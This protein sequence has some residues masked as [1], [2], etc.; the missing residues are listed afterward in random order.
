MAERSGECHGVVLGVL[1]VAVERR[2]EEEADG[3]IMLCQIHT[4]PND[5]WLAAWPCLVPVICESKAAQR[6]STV[7][8]R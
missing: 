8:T 3:G 2:E 4:Q 1:V 5:G 7:D 6:T